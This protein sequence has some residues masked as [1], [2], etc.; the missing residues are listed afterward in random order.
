MILAYSARDP[1]VRG[2]SIDKVVDGLT[3]RVGAG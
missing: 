1:E 3:G 2:R